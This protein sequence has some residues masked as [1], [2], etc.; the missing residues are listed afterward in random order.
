[1]SRE[2]ALKILD[3]FSNSPNMV[4]HALA[5]EAVMRKLGD[6]LQPGN[7]H[8]W[9]L[10]GLLHDADYEKTEKSLET[11]TDL[12]TEKL[13]GKVSQ[14]VIDAIRGH[15]DKVP[16]KTLMAKSIYAADELTGLVVATALV[17]PDK[18]L[19]AVSLESVLKKFKDPSFARGANR[20]Q[21]KTCERELGIPLPEF[22]AVALSSMQTVSG[23]LDL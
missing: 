10:V 18:K 8:D 1:M 3:D 14:D 19:N 7:V 15:C 6:R 2:E 12:V 21:I 17:H 4:K 9:G 22:V 5:A 11:H 23:D 20:N 16:R 13:K